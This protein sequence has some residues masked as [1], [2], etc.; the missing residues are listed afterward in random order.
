M[1]EATQLAPRRGEQ[2][3]VI[4]SQPPSLMDCLLHAPRG[5]ELLLDRPPQAI[6]RLATLKPVQRT[7]AAITNPIHRKKY[8]E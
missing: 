3:V 1:K 2:A 4:S 6:R 5:E 8:D 7:P